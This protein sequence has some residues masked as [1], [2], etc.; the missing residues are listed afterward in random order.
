MGK[1]PTYVQPLGPDY[2]Y[3]EI[4]TDTVEVSAGAT[5]AGAIP[6]LG[7]EGVLDPSLIPGGSGS[8]GPT[9][10]TGPTGPSGIG[11]TPSGGFEIDDGTFL[12]GSS[13]FAFD[14]GAF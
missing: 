4:L 8:V 13:E 6:V 7:P 11:T 3:Q 5:S 10:P 2:P 1:I 14:D 12:A 9:G